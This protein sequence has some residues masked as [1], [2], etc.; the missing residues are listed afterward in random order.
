MPHGRGRRVFA[1]GSVYEGEF[2]EGRISGAGKYE[3]AL[4]ETMKGTFDEG[5]LQGLGKTT[6]ITGETYEGQF[7]D[8]EPHGLGV[9]TNSKRG[10]SYD[11]AW[12]R[13]QRSGRG[14]ERFA[15]GSEYDGYFFL[16]HR[17][18]HGTLRYGKAGY[19]KPR[20]L[21]ADRPLTPRTQARFDREAKE[22]EDA[23]ARAT[24]RI[25]DQIAV[26]EYARRRRHLD[27]TTSADESRRRR[28]RRA[29]IPRRRVAS[30]LPRG[31][32]AEARRG[33]VLGRGRT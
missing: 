32:S 8:G 28:G 31:Y 16:D 2:K 29:D 17:C 6:T 33:D 22:R 5:V 26:S 21:R 27:G 24:E 30:R 19:T 18:G 3:S 20:K 11:G 10:E 14:T 23:A 25:S 1:D 12:R 9:Y 13:G 7:L 4:G 15:D